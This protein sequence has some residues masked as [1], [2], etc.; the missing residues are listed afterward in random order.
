MIEHLG[1]GER[2]ALLVAG[3]EQR[4]EDVSAGRSPSRGGRGSR[5]RPGARARP[6]PASAG[7]R[8]CPDRPSAAGRTPRRGRR[9]RARTRSRSR[10]REPSRGRSRTA[11]A[12]RSASPGPGSS[13]RCRRPRRRRAPRSRPRASA[14]HRL[15]RD[16]DP[17][18]VEGG[19]HDRPR[20]VVVVAVGGQQA[21]AEQR[22]QVTEAPVAPDE[23]VA[24]GD[25]HEVVR[26]RADHEDLAVV[27]DPQAEDRPVCV[28]VVEQQVEDVVARSPGRASG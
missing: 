6:A 25:E 28:V 10:G 14:R 2:V 18:L 1:V 20:G 19:H 27:E 4:A 8:A 17:L 7:R 21:V 11:P 22:D 24:S 5:R 16:R 9:A 23:V 15:G 13:G 12:S 26:L 3:A